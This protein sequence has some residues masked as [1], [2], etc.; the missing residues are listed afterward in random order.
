MITVV[1]SFYFS[2]NE[3]FD[4]R[5]SECEVSDA[6]LA[7]VQPTKCG[8]IRVQLDTSQTAQLVT[9][10]WQVVIVREVDESLVVSRQE[11]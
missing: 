8:R 10:N 5:L 9:Q 7:S 2:C 11:L 4:A 3:L 6:L 1:Q